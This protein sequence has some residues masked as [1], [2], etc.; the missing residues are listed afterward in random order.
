MVSDIDMLIVRSTV[1]CIDSDVDKRQT[2]RACSRNGDGCPDG[3][4]VVG[5]ITP[6]FLSAVCRLYV[7]IH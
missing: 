2:A 4:P 3:C 7:Y 6:T 1:G 5:S